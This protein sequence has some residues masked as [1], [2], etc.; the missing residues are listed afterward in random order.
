[1]TTRDIAQARLLSQ[2]IAR[3]DAAHPEEVVRCMAALQAQDEAQANWAVGLRTKSATLAAVEQQLEEAKIVLTWPNRGTLHYV[4]AEDLRWLLSLLGPRNLSRARRR[5]EKLELDRPTLAKA[6][7]VVGKA[8]GGGHRIDRSSLLR[9][10][11][12]NGVDPSGQRA[13]HI[14]WYLGQKQFLCFGP[15]EGGHQTFVLVEEWVPAARERGHDE[16]LSEL[17]SRYFASHGPATR[18][19]FSKWAGITE[20][21]AKLGIEAAAGI[22]KMQVEE[23]ELLSA[24]GVEP[25]RRAKSSVGALL[26]G[27]DEYLLGYR[28]REDVLES[29]HADRVVPGGNG[30][31]RPMMVLDGRIVG[32]WRRRMLRDHLEIELEPF[33]GYRVEARMFAPAA[34][35][36]SAFTGMGCEIVVK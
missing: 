27:F 34:K 22:K 4:H 17:A 11:A 7:E 28:N 32:T 35:R 14:L 21:D 23:R 8:L 10:L 1:M 16:A 15:R 3:P 20:G 2:R 9:L 12:D 33:D 18:K 29:V 13:Y 24:G 26:P 5:L 30:M 31:F 36:Y 19:D 6:Q 25:V